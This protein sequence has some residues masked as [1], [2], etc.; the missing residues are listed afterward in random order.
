MFLG[1][2]VSRDYECPVI[3]IKNFFNDFVFC[4]EV[5]Y[6]EM[7]VVGVFQII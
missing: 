1:Q 6:L 4:F 3:C 5:Q 7:T 2:L